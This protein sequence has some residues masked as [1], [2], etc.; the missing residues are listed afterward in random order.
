[1]VF[2]PYA[3]PFPDTPATDVTLGNQQRAVLTLMAQ[4]PGHVFTTEELATKLRLPALTPRRADVIMGGINDVLGEDAVVTVPRRG[5]ML[6]PYLDAPV[7][8]SF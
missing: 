7:T 8:I 2:P 6:A 4:R 5:W 3:A 1:M